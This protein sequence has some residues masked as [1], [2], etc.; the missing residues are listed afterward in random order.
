MSDFFISYTSD[1]SQWAQWIARELHA[2]GHSAHVHEW[3]LSGGRD[4]YAWMEE[5]MDAADH[6]VC[7]ASEDYLKAPFSR[8]ERNAALWQAASSRPGFVLFVAVKPCRLPLLAAHMR[9]CELF[10]VSEEVAR[11]RFREFLSLPR[12]ARSIAFPG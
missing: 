1:D 8:L 10:G 9:R 5:R 3:E 6:V 12:L 11:T 2:L 4:I 7:V